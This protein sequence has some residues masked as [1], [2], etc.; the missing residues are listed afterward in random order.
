MPE[1]APPGAPQVLLGI[2]FGLRRIGLAVGDTVTGRARPRP[3]L[4]V[5]AGRE[6]GEPEFERLARE[7][8]D[9]GAARIVV[10]C[11]YN[12]DGTQ[13]ALAARAAGFAAEL[14]RRHRLPVHLVDERYS[15]LEATETLR[16]MRASGARRSRV[17][18]PDVDSAAAAVILE[19]WMAG[20]GER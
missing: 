19:R 1:P 10:G 5:A 13:G 18:K 7:L 15:S 17:A 6:P 9:S 20:E 11:P 2:D 16:T 14:G 4:V 3:A 12:P 8:R